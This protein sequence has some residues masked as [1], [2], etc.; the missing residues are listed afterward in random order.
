MSSATDAPSLNMRFSGTDTLASGDDSNNTTLNNFTIDSSGNTVDA[1]GNIVCP[2]FVRPEFDA[3]ILPVYAD[4]SQFKKICFISSSV[5]NSV[6]N[7]GGFSQYLANDT[8]PVVYDYSSDRAQLKA[9]L[10]AQFTSI[11][12]VSFAFHGL[13]VGSTSFSTTRFLNV[14]NFFDMEADGVTVTAGGESQVFLQDLFTAWNVKNVDFLGCELLKSPEW[15]QY[16]GLFQNVVV[17]ASLDKTGNVQYGGNWVMENTMQNICDLY[18]NSTI[19]NYTGLLIQYTYVVNSNWSVLYTINTSDKVT[20]VGMTVVNTDLLLTF[21]SSINSKPVIRV[22]GIQYSSAKSISIPNS[23]TSI[24]HFRQS[25]FLTSVVMSENVTVFPNLAFYA[26]YVLA[27]FNMPPKV[28]SIGE[29]AFSECHLL[30]DEHLPLRSTLTTIGSYAFGSSSGIRNAVV[31]G[32]VTSLA[33]GAF[34]GSGLLSI[35]FEEGITA[36]PENCCQN[37]GSLSHISFPKTLT[38]IGPGSFWTINMGGNNYNPNMKLIFPSSVTTINDNAFRNAHI[39]NFYWCGNSIPSIL[40]NIDLAIFSGNDYVAQYYLNTVVDVTSIT[41]WNQSTPIKLT[42]AAMFTQLK[43]DLFTVSEIYQ[44]GFLTFAFLR[45]QYTITQMYNG[46]VTVGQMFA[47]GVTFAEMTADSTAISSALASIILSDTSAYVP[48][49][50]TSSGSTVTISSISTLD[51]TDPSI[52]GS[53]VAEQKSF[54]SATVAALFAANSVQKQ[55]VLPIGSVLPGFSASLTKRVNLINASSAIAN[56]RVTILHKADI[57]SQ[58]FYALLESDDT[59]Q[60]ETNS[61]LVTISK[62]GS[63]FTLITNTGTTSTNVAGDTYVYDG[64]N[65]TLGSVYGILNPT[66]VDL[67][68]TALDSQIQLNTSARI[69]DYSLSIV[70]DATITLNTSVSASVLQNTFYFRGDTDIATDASFVYYYVDSSQWAN[71]NTTLS[72]KNGM[73]T[74]NMYVTS[75]PVGKDFL[76]DLAR[77]LFGTYIAADLFTNEDA[78]I[79]DINSKCD[80]VSANIVALINSVDI[81]MGTFSGLLSDSSGN[82]YLP[83]NLSTTNISRELFNMLMTSAPTRFVSTSPTYHFYMGDTGFYK[84]PILAGDTISF[85]LTVTPAAGQTSAVQTG[86]TTLSSRVYTV[87]MNISE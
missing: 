26:N 14:K 85:K 47:G 41:R 87:K 53:T 67:I 61:G 15:K 73:V 59:L 57:L 42:A 72:P 31:P 23:V 29:S 62:S 71:K 52:I 36:I 64:L 6:E 5:E 8:Y 83:D 66:S 69:A 17:G 10:L 32:S 43:T 79:T 65:I 51:L 18:F 81:S 84:M 55:L 13:P 19:G 25:S 45:T 39:R 3:V 21:P 7:G 80:T 37:C 76:R 82:K 48:T 24:G 35:V 27:S 77:Q 86:K 60:I 56:G 34:A 20:I 2:A 12:R 54:T 30:T 11:D 74:A 78:V 28:V 49:I 58:N 63:V 44:A 22:E 46:G 70:S 38:S 33:I 40:N 4:Y 68:L 75:D 16:F 9:S 50:P 1:S